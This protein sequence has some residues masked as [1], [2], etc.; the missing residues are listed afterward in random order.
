MTSDRS[1]HGIRSA[2]RSGPP[3]LS[4]LLLACLLLTPQTLVGQA[5]KDAREEPFHGTLGR[6]A[7]GGLG[8]SQG[9]SMNGNSARS[10]SMAEAAKTQIW[11]DLEIAEL[12]EGLGSDSYARRL[13]SRERLMRAGLAAFE[14]LLEAKK[15]PDSE[16][17]IV[18]GKL[19][20]GN[21]VRWAK[22]YESADVQA[23][24]ADFGDLGLEGRLKRLE[25]LVEL[26][27]K[28]SLAALL[29][30]ARYGDDE[31][32]RKAA[33][34]IMDQ[35]ASSAQDR[36]TPN[37]ETL[38]E[39]SEHGR[40]ILDLMP[41]RD[42]R[43]LRWL[44]L[45][46]TEWTDARTRPRRWS[47][48]IEQDR[49]E[50]KHLGDALSRDLWRVLRLSAKRAVG[51]GDLEG[52]GQ[53]VS[54]HLSMVPPQTR[55][56]RDLSYWCLDQ[57]LASVVLDLQQMHGRIFSGSALLLYAAAEASV[58]LR[59]DDQVQQLVREARELF[60]LPPWVAPKPKSP[61]E[62]A[63]LTPVSQSKELAARA[64]LSVG[65]GLADRGLFEWM[66]E[67]FRLVIDGLPNDSLYAAEARLQLAYVFGQLDRH[68]KVVALLEPLVE[69][70]NKDDR[71][72]HRIGY[73]R[74]PTANPSSQLAFHRGRLA[75]E[76]GRIEAAQ[77]AYREALHHNSDNIDILIA[78]FHL[79]GNENWRREVN[80]LLRDEVARSLRFV[81]A[82]AG[83]DAHEK[84]KWLNH[85]AWLISNTK[86][87]F[88]RALEYSQQSLRVQPADWALMDT[89]ARC[90]FALG[91]VEQAIQM[92]RRA[93]RLAPHSAPLKR[94]LREFE[95]ALAL[96][97]EN[98][99][100]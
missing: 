41:D 44:R 92:Q 83:A 53:L 42:T 23:L 68:A 40:L 30:I 48:M 6:A 74:F 17:A 94:Q 49:Q 20:L 19:T 90:H 62:E 50:V 71:F 32:S 84:A 16:I 60:P 79:D 78:M 67:E 8:D 76:Q 59:D 88:E 9:T 70:I 82:T 63:E 46:A 65:A 97:P 57:G 38:Y 51:N 69:R 36:W 21:H 52:A 5:L 7:A 10:T 27:A 25:S 93:L 75:E 15:H 3:I 35:A 47:E 100:G 28:E 80:D 81:Q 73:N 13:R 1:R 34:A 43:A 77:D 54:S 91:Q 61:V 98:V 64:H 45:L 87:D 99:S 85:Y 31:L 22:S 11:T 12:I 2:L 14:Q 29:R 4:C 33:I 37:G 72:K 89:C 26:P 56:I 58:Q 95:A 39:K 24:L 96:A 86:G 66:E 55:E 18:A